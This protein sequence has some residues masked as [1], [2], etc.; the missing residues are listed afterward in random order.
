MDQRYFGQHQDLAP[1]AIARELGGSLVWKQEDHGQW[2]A[3][4]RF[5]RQFE[6]RVEDS[7]DSQLAL[8]G[9]R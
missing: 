7:I 4:I 9:S 1:E 2:V 3:L 5:N 8:N 6:A